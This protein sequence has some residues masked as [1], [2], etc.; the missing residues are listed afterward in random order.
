[1]KVKLCSI[2]VIFLSLSLITCNVFNAEPYKE[3]NENGFRSIALTG[4]PMGIMNRLAFGTSSR[5]VY[6]TPLDQDRSI[7]PYGC[8]IQDSDGGDFPGYAGDRKIVITAI[9]G[10]NNAGKIAG[11][12]DGIAYYFKEVDKDKNFRISADFYIDN[13]GFTGG[14]PDLNG[15]EAFGIMAR[16]YVPQYDIDTGNYTME[17]LKTV[18]WDGRYYTGYNRPDGPGGSGNMIMVGGVKRGARVY[19]RTG[20]DDPSEDNEAI[21]NP[22]YV[23]RAD[24][25]KFYFLPREFA[26]YSSYGSGKAG[27]ESRPDFPSAGLTYRLSLEKTNSGFKAKI[28][29]PAGVGKGTTKDRIPKDGQVLEYSD[30]E[31]PFPDLLFEINKEKYYVGFFA[32]RDARVTITNISYE[33]SDA[34][35]CPKRVDPPPENIV[36][37]FSVQSPSAVSQ[38]GYTL[39]ARSNVEGSLLV[40][41]NGKEAKAYNGV[42]ITEPTNASAEPFSLFEIPVDALSLGDNVFSLVFNPDTNQSKSGY[43]IGKE[44]LM[45]NIKP[46][47][48]SFTVNYRT[49]PDGDIYVSPEGKSSNTGTRDSP[50][51]I[52]TAISYVAPGQTI[53]LMDGIYTPCE[54]PQMINGKQRIP[55]R[56]IIPRYNSGKPNLAVVADPEKPTDAERGKSEYYK[57]FKVMK[58]EH[59]DKAIFDFR[60]DWTMRGY[61]SRGFEL[62]G[63]YWHIEGIHIR[64]TS[65]SNKGF[66]VFGSH[67]RLSWVKTYFNGDTGFQVSGRSYEPK[68]MWPSYNR[69]EY[70]ESFA[71]ADDSRTNADGF[72]AKL[73]CGPGNYFYRCISH[74]NIDD[75]YD[76]FA[77]KE[78]GPI[79]A[80]VLE[81]CFAYMNGRYMNAEI[82]SIYG[83]TGPKPGDS[84]RA[85]GNGFKMGGEGI[86]VSHLAINCL[87]FQNDGDGFTSNSDPAVRI[88]YCTSV[89]NDNRN[90]QTGS[91]SSN[92]AIYGAGSAS[93]EGLDAVITQI[94]SWWS[95][96]RRPRRDDRVEPKSPASGYVWRNGRSVSTLY[97]DGKVNGR[98][99]Y[100]D[101]NIMND[102]NVNDSYNNLYYGGKAAFSGNVA[103]FDSSIIGDFLEVDQTT[104][105]PKLGDFMKITGITGVTPGIQ[106]MW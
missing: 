19:W 62:Q 100:E 98:N 26:D 54:A 48:Q 46:I 105:K 42:W 49:L 12:E 91:G 9:N 90:E 24:F 6:D 85:G 35:L 15:Q 45:T 41:M 37:S 44:Y 31:L 79:G 96:A 27:I 5:Q 13:Y 52:M 51:D 53:I 10:T 21:T 71:N 39:I 32:A 60:K 66:T 84:T 68:S 23:A 57:Y 28:T 87:S 102:S 61:D 11:S 86:S 47:F 75:G 3:Q 56:L 70:C 20:V 88:T 43:L 50:M 64:N 59:R 97:I 67:N 106:G 30:R 78:T 76:F 104:G 25:A 7:R 8:V 14:R 101:G 77:K 34:A 74:H 80:M 29:P 69:I 4:G 2:L 58:A 82:A 22:N 65:D 92:Y 95:S 93:H 89:D 55:I 38:A 1:M 33:E 94:F 18:R 40:S 16:D 103:P 36:P 81:E 99:K 63:D 73:T 83:G 72:G 17:A